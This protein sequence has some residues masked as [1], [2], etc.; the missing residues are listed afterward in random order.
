[1]SHVEVIRLLGSPYS[2]AVEVRDLVVPEG[3]TYALVGNMAWAVRNLVVRGRLIVDDNSLLKVYGEL[4]LEGQGELVVRG[5][6]T[7]EVVAL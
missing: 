4:R 5:N 1:M 2:Q 3:A 7:V 6:A